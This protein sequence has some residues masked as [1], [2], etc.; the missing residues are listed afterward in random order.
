MIRSMLRAITCAVAVAALGAATPT[1]RAGFVAVLDS[2]APGG[3]A[4]VFSYSLIFSSNG[5]SEQLTDGNILTLYDFGAG[6]ADGNVVVSSADFTV[7]VQDVGITPVPGSGS[8]HP[9]DSASISNITFKYSGPDLFADATFVAT[10]TLNGAYTTRLGEYASQDTFPSAPGGTNTA[11]GSVFLPS[12]AAAVPEPASLS[13][14]GAGALGVLG[15]A[16]RRKAV[17]AARS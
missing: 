13:L 3:S 8:I 16:R 6:V 17:A 15:Y 1:A 7:T 14:L 5:G 12:L 4:S 10:I 9:V 11:V 2:P